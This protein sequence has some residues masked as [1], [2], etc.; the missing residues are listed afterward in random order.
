M[1]KLSGQIGQRYTRRD[2]QTMTE[3]KLKLFKRFKDYT[4]TDLVGK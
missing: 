1:N 2:S 3:K 4:H